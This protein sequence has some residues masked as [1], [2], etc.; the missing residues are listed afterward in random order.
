M[1]RPGLV[2]ALTVL[3]V[4]A[5]CAA[6]L[7]DQPASQTDTQGT[8]TPDQAGQQTTG[9]APADDGSGEPPT[10]PQADPEADRL[11]WEAGYW[12]NDPVAA[13]N[14]DGL[15]ASERK[16]VIGRA[17]ARVERVRGLEFR[18]PV[19]VSVVGRGE[20][21]AGDLGG[22]TSDA[23]RT[24]DNAKFEALL[25]V[26]STEDSMST[27]DASLNA[28]VGG[29]YSTERNAIVLVSDSAMPTIDGEKTL[30][31]ELVHALQDQHFDLSTPARFR[32]SHNGK[33]GLVE[34][35]AN[36]V[37][38]IY[39]SR[40]GAGWRCLQSD[41]NS[42]GSGS[43]GS[44]LHMGVYLLEYFPYADGPSLIAHLRNG[45]GWG[46]VNDAYDRVPTSATEVI[47]PKRYGS[48]QPQDVSLVDTNRDGWTRVRPP[49]RPD[50]GRLGQSALSA[51]FAYTLYDDYNRTRVIE[52]GQFLNSRMGQLNE[53]DPLNYDLPPVRG[54]I[55]DRFHAYEREGETA[56][57]W[58][59]DWA[60]ADDAE[61]FAAA[62][63]DLLT[64]WGGERVADNTWRFSADSP[65]SG[66]VYLAVTDEH[67][68]IAK[69]PTTGELGQVY[70][71]AR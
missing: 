4:L 64:H 17:M 3:V 67:V 10:E 30:G 7:A 50:F 24:F 48:F 21:S 31:H 12:Y 53:S 2:A 69:A 49:N 22:E 56:Y 63:R 71:G 43:S 57:V 5:G 54:W 16:A 70:A 13:T 23:L 60:S 20:F 61:R 14:D 34:G 40:C 66:A 47:Y 19:N 15:N 42:G 45:S 18:E 26:G 8:G 29:Y 65:F 52:P 51:M 25:L 58:Q 6:P 1:R 9:P 62:Y 46:A 44:D 11:G 35:D 32:D 37:Q 39:Q 36:A 38:Q 27:Q 55:G 28:T 41:G 68:V 33:N 59:L